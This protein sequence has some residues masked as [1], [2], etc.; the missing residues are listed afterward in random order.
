[1]SNKIKANIDIF[2][3]WPNSNGRIYTQEA[4]DNMKKSVESRTIYVHAEPPDGAGKQSLNSICGTVDKIHQEGPL[5]AEMSVHNDLMDHMIHRGMMEISPCGQGSVNSDG[6][7]SNYELRSFSLV[8]KVVV[9]DDE[10][11]EATLI[12][13]ETLNQ[14]ND[15]IVFKAHKRGMILA[16]CLDGGLW[17][18]YNPKDQKLYARLDDVGF[19]VH[20]PLMSDKL[21]CRLKELFSRK[22]E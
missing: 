9:D 20:D 11:D 17:I 12:I 22:K 1:M 18:I 6:T 15:D 3:D 16:G 2:C 5:M 13:C 14:N 10:L 8:A 7:I 21:I 4:I 19:D